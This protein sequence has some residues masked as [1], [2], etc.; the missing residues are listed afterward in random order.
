[1]AF[2]TVE[3]KPSISDYTLLQV[4]HATTVVLRKVLGVTVDVFLE[5][6]KIDIA[7]AAHHRCRPHCAVVLSPLYERHTRARRNIAV[8]RG[9]DHDFGQNR[10]TSRLALDDDAFDFIIADQ[11]F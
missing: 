10:L 9:I 7:K 11:R 8:A 5:P 1:M 2:S 4:D 6:P 3:K